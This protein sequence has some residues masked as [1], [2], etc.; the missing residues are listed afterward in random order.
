MIC[1]SGTPYGGRSVSSLGVH[2]QRSLPPHPTIARPKVE[3]LEAG[4]NEHLV[5]TRGDGRQCTSHPIRGDTPNE[6]IVNI[7][8]DLLGDRR[9]AEHLP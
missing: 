8:S 5:I 2:M 4:G 3:V 6:K 1:E 7:V 9:T